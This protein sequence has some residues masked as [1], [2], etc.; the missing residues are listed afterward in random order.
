MS[1]E[2]TPGLKLEAGTVA[3][4]S[5]GPWAGTGAA[6]SWDWKAWHMGWVL[7]LRARN[8]TLPRGTWNTKLQNRPKPGNPSI[9]LRVVVRVVVA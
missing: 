9:C 5:E 6:W 7:S 1:E 4:A 2:N 3:G 8:P